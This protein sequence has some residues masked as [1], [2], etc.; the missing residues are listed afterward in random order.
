MANIAIN[1]FGRIGRQV[2]KTISAFFPEH[3]IVA[4][5]DITNPET[6]VHLLRYDSNYGKYNKRIE[7]ISSDT[8]VVDGKKTKC[9]MYSD[10]A[11]LPWRENEIDI[12]VESTG[13]FKSRVDASVHIRNGAKKVFVSAPMKDPDLTIVRG[14]NDDSYDP[15]KHQVIS[16][17][18]CTTNSLAPIVNVL[19]KKYEVE[20]GFMT[21]IHS[22]TG[23]QR[24]LDAPHTDMRRARNA[25]TNIVPTSTGA[26]NSVGIVIPELAGKLTGISVRVPTSTVSLTDFVCRLKEDIG[27]EQINAELERAS[28]FEL[29]GIIDYSEEPLVSSDYLGSPYSGTVD[30]LSTQVLG[31]HMLKICIWYDNEWGYSVRSAEV[32]DMIAKS[33]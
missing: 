2:F 3:N 6:L 5:N 31:S 26:A 4:V 15:E 27:V 8:F 10:P 22:Y 21:T 9:L 33:I 32:V 28:K 23:D 20:F 25:A 24:L 29:S 7:L 11:N 19:H 16:N 14:V 13:R 18:S 30:A 1:G 17:A 12:V